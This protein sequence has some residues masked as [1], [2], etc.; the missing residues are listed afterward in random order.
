[1][2]RDF[3]L[4]WAGH[5][6]SQ[7]GTSASMVAVP[8]VAV[9]TL[10]ASALQVALLSAAV[11][12]PWLLVGIPAGTLVD[13]LPRRPVLI[14]CDLLCALLL[15][16]APV[17]A[18]LGLLSIGQLLL[19]ALLAGTCDVFASTAGQVYLPSL[20]PP[21]RLE[22]GNARLQGSA[23]AAQVAGPRVAGLLAHLGGAVTAL[24]ADAASYLV[25]AACLLRI[26]GRGRVVPDPGRESL[27][28]EARV[29]LR[30]AARDPY[31]RVLAGFGAAS[32]LALTSYQAVLIVFL[33]REVGLGPGAVGLL[34]SLGGLG[35]VLGAVL[36]TPL[37]RAL[38]SARALLACEIGAGACA[39][40]LPLTTSGWGV[41][42]FVLGDLGLA[43]GVVAGNVLNGS[44]RQRYV[45]AALLGRVTASMRVLN[46]GTMPLAA[47][48]GGV[49]ATAIG[50]RPTLWAGT[51][52]V[53]AATAVLLLGPLKSAR[54]LPDRPA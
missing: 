23:S 12:L 40:L 4:L 21:D 45:P 49:L 36:A 18:W 42:W 53:L 22:R 11:W 33:V 2:N 8:L 30:F 44:F 38:G 1:M 9:T 14:L 24:V 54:D 29:G 37:S 19:V 50:L 15:L 31:L 47:V 16:S 10:H 52:A 34:L 41:A 13:R 46:Y 43:A 7:L 35:G 48:L 39:L 26:R 5:T 25:S 6:V 20:V 27:L 28:A 3:R 17:A 32:N 51:A